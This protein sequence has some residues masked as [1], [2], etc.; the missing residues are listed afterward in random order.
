MI[1]PGPPRVLP[2]APRKRRVL[3]VGL[4]KAPW[5]GPA[6]RPDG[7]WPARLAALPSGRL[8]PPLLCARPG[9]NRHAL[10]GT[11]SSGWRVCLFPP[12]ARGAAVRCQPGPLRLTRASAPVGCSAAGV[13]SCW[14]RIRTCTALSQSQVSSPVRPSSIGTGSGIRTRMSR[15]ARRG[16]G[17]VRLPFRHSRVRRASGRTRTRMVPV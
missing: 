7:V 1:C 17:P 13:V 2:R 4:A 11:S 9:S 6:G 12:R 5:P 10:V 14:S 16:L 3:P 15:E 8:V